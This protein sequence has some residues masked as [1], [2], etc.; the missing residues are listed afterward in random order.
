MGLLIPCLLPVQPGM[1]PVEGAHG[2]GGSMRVVCSWEQPNSM[3]IRRHS[4]MVAAWDLD[5]GNV[6]QQLQ[7]LCTSNQERAVGQGCREPA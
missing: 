7:G 4:S 6:M 1:P 3:S 5:V 2:R